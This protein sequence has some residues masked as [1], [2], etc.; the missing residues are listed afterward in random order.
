MK[1]PQEVSDLND[2]QGS[3]H[4]HMAYMRKPYNLLELKYSAYAIFISV[5]HGVHSN[6]NCSE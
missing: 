6:C 5:P 4:Y 2:Q 3:P 1:R